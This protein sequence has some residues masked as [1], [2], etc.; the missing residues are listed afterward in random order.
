MSNI[1]AVNLADLR[2]PNDKQGR[3][4]RQVNAEMAHAI[5][6][7]ALVEMENGCR[8][9]VV[10]HGRDCDMTPLYSL[11]HDKDDTEQHRPQ[12]ANY[13]WVN[14]IGEESIKIIQRG[15]RYGTN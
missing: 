9:Y 3:S 12:F 11:S 7:G 8:L 6:V 5:P 14:G 4:Y 10:Y 1:V 15:E 2:D 13:S